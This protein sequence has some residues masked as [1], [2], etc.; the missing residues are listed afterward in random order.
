M[1]ERTC[2][3]RA[4]ERQ[5]HEAEREQ[6]PARWTY[7]E[8]AET[9]EN[10]GQVDQLRAQ[11]TKLEETVGRMERM[12]ARLGGNYLIDD[13]LPP[14]AYERLVPGNGIDRPDEYEPTV[15]D[16][17]DTAL[18]AEEEPQNWRHSEADVD[19]LIEMI[20]KT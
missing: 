4:I 7:P 16:Y 5:R 12:I 1:G 20:R 9:W 13:A 2:V 17:T 18:A 10:G 6:M 19:G 15:P 8:R 14:G 3:D 11:V